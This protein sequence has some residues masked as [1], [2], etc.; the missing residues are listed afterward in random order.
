MKLRLSAAAISLACSALAQAQVPATSVSVAYTNLNEASLNGGGKTSVGSAQLSFSHVQGLSG[1]NTL[2]LQLRA[3]RD[4]WSFDGN[5][6]FGRAPWGDVE[7][8]TLGMPFTHTLNQS[9]QLMLTP[10]LESAKETTANSGDALTWG[11]S[12]GA[13]KIYGQGQVLGLGLSGFSGLDGKAKVFP[14]PIVNWRFNDSWRVFNPLAL[15]P[16]GPAGLEL[17]FNATSNLEIGLGGTWRSSSFR[18][19]G[20]NALAQDGVGTLSY[21]PVF[22]HASWKPAPAFTLNAY[23]AMALNG[24]LKVQ[25]KQGDDISKDG[26]ENTPAI[27]VSGSFRF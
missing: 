12:T 8:Y 22:L 18:L 11:L 3:D 21:A 23:A 25:S 19:A 20:N 26:M 1:G 5:N 4:N 13:F 10:S 6:S 14:F 2:G 9:W 24:R 7:R 15:G 16:A 27:G 17:G